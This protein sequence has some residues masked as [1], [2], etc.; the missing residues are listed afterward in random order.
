[1]G[2]LTTTVVNNQLFAMPRSQSS[3]RQVI[4][5]HYFPGKKE[6]DLAT[7]DILD[8]W[9][10]WFLHAHEY[11]AEEL[12]RLLPPPEIR[13]AAETLERIARISEDKAMYDAREKALRDQQWQLNSAFREGQEKGRLEGQREGRL[14]GR[15]EGERE[16]EIRGKI[17]LIRTLQAILCVPMSEEQELRA[18]SWE[19]LQSLTAD[20]QERIRNRPST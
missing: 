6:A 5:S 19:Q 9:L 1:M 2:L 15:Q 16:G 18:L 14:E 10:Y 4:T 11:E 17:E 8:C 13:Q 20:L 12:R 7:A 3:F